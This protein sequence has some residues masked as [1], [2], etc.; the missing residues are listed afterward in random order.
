MWRIHLFHVRSYRG[1][2]MRKM[3][4]EWRFFLDD[5]WISFI[6]FPSFLFLTDIVIHS[7]KIFWHFKHKVIMI[8]MQ[9]DTEA[10]ELLLKIF[11]FLRFMSPSWPSHCYEFRHNRKKSPSGNTNKLSKCGN[12]WNFRHF[13]FVLFLHQNFFF[14]CNLFSLHSILILR[15]PLAT[16]RRS[17]ALSKCFEI[18][19]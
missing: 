15:A 4:I 17:F 18:H 1:I 5:I 9:N 13:F 16:I 10:T 19:V 12:P 11:E 2:K 3:W 8:H 14:F 6:F 7:N